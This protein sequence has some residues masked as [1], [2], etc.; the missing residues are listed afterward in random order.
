MSDIGHVVSMN[1]K[2]L[3]KERQLTLQELSDLSYV[4]TS[5]LGSIERG[6]TNPTITTLDKIATGFKVPLSH[7]LEEDQ[8]SI[9]YIDSNERKPYK[10]ES[11]YNVLTTFAY[12]K[13]YGFQVLEIQ[14]EPL[15]ERISQGHNKGVVEFLIVHKNSV[16]LEIDNKTFDLDEGDAI[17][18]EAD[19][20]HKLINL[21]KKSAGITNIIYYN[22]T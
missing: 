12:D 5:M 18:F 4:S 15:C 10:T 14:V 16:R 13:H 2:A 9:L 1:I 6:D 17:R 20:P 11:G 3:R 21:T 19:K 22:R 7:I 8:K